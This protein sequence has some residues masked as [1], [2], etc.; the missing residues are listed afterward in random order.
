MT[1]E[2]IDGRKIAEGVRLEVREDVGRLV[3]EY[4]IKPGLA[5]VLVG[6][7]PASVSYVA[8]KEKAAQE[9]GI[10]TTTFNLPADTHEEDVLNLIEELNHAPRFHGILVQLPLQ[11]HTDTMAVVSAIDPMKDVDGLHPANGGMLLSG[12]PRFIPCTPAGVHRLLLAAGYPPDGKHV[13]ICGRSPIV[14]SP[15]AALLLLKEVGANATVTVCHTGTP[16]IAAITRQADILIAATGGRPQGITGEMVK[17]GTVVVDVGIHRV[18]DPSKKMGY[19]LV[20]DVDID[21]VKEKAKAITPVPGGVGPMTVA[22][23][24]VNTLK[25]ARLAVKTPLPGL[26]SQASP[27]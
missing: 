14:G 16:D 20:G 1:A 8:S 15:M 12:V 26:T 7:D 3:R 24:L 22:M 11:E 5:V 9:A 18:E 25:A 10:D 6:E 4:G 27:G 21:S 19:R 2:I 13:V 17:E 23:L